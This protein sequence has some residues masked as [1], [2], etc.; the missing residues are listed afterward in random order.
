M[1]QR[2]R[3]FKGEK[4][5]SSF[6]GLFELSDGDM[7]LHEPAIAIFDGKTPVTIRIAAQTEGL[8]VTF[9]LSDARLISKAANE[10]GIVVTVLPNEGT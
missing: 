8:P 3:K 1:L 2:F 9:A 7:A 5:L 10:K 4:G 6:V